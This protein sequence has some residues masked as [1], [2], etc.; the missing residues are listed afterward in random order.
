MRYGFVTC[1]QLGF[2]CIEEIYSA[3]SEIKLAITLKDNISREKSG[4]I[5]LDNF[6]KDNCIDLLKCNNVNDHEVISAINRHNIDWLFIIGWSQIAQA[7][8][9]NAPN[10]GV[11]GI[12]PTLLPIGRGRA[13]IPWAI[14]KGYTETGVTLFK[15]DKGVDTGSILRQVIVPISSD[16]TAASL[17]QRVREAHRDLIRDVWSDLDSYSIELLPQDESKATFWPK[18]RPDDGELFSTLT[19]IEADR[20]VRGVTKPYPGAFIQG[21]DATYRIWS[22]TLVSGVKLNN[23]I[24]IVK[25]SIRFQLADGCLESDDW[26]KESL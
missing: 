13:P 26:D 22:A 25:G 1:V 19:C 8:I 23:Y 11:L 10:C 15:L 14:I 18:R 6:C 7:E 16:E 4:R 24:Q 17:Y 2:S 21:P 3:G 12:H 5:Y 20:L 9:L